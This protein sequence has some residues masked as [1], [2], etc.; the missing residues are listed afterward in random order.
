VGGWKGK[1]VT[2]YDPLIGLKR[3]RRGRKNLLFKLG[4]FV[5]RSRESSLRRLAQKAGKWA[6]IHQIHDATQVTPHPMRKV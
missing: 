2:I 4:V 5:V 1:E 6:I 3:E